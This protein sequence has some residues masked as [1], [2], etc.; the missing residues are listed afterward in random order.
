MA[1]DRCLPDTC[2]W[3]DFFNGRQTPL[4]VA[5]ERLLR[6]GEA[7]TC[8]AVKYELI[9]GVKTDREER[10]LLGALTAVTHLEMNET[11]WIKA[12]RLSGKLRK[13][14]VTLPYSD[15]LIAVL[16][17]EHGLSILST[18]RHFEQVDGVRVIAGD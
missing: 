18:D 2:A 9:Q 16:A 11:L 6:E 14:G 12:G 8:G 7:Y 3:I 17:L 4:T 13:Q 15:I 10:T 1:N 5:L